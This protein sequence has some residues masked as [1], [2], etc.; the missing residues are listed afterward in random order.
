MSALIGALSAAGE[1][2]ANPLRGYL[3]G[4]GGFR[5]QRRT[6]QATPPALW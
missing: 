4:A 3:G 2:Q 6:L 5:S 1:S